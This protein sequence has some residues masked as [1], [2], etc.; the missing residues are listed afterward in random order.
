MKARIK[1]L[2]FFLLLIAVPLLFFYKIFLGYSVVAGDFSG[3]D[4][5]DLHLPLKYAAH[6]QLTKL[7]VPLWNKNLS[8][9]F[10][11]LADGHSGFFYP[12]NYLLSFFPPIDALNLDIL[13]VFIVCFIGSYL[14]FASV[15]KERHTAFFFAVTFTFSAYFIARIKHLSHTTPAS[16]FPLLLYFA[17]KYFDRKSYIYILPTSITIAFIFFAGHPQTV[18]Y[19]VFFFLIYCF[20]EI[21]RHM[22]NTRTKVILP[23][24]VTYLSLSLLLGI[25]L[26]AVQILPTVEF[27]S[28]SPRASLSKESLNAYPFNPKNLIT[29]IS[30]YFYGNPANGTYHEDIRTSGIFWENASYFGLLPFA[31]VIFSII[32][33]IR[34]KL[35][36]PYVKFYLFLAIFSALLTLGPFTPLFSYF[37]DNL[38]IFGFFRF[39]TRFN[40]YL[41]FSLSALSAFSFSYLLKRI[42]TRKTNIPAKKGSSDSFKFSWPFTRSQTAVLAIIFVLV[43]LFVFANAYIGYIP[44]NKLLVEPSYADKIKKDSRYY[45]FYSTTQYNPSPYSTLGWIGHNDAIITSRKSI[46]P[47]NS[48]LFN[49]P[50]FTD[51]SWFEGALSV[52]RRND[53]EY[54]L[55]YGNDNPVNTGRIL[56]M[57]SVKYI[58]SFSDY[59]GVEV[60]QEKK[61]D[62]G[63]PFNAPLYLY[64]NEL[65][66]PRVYFAPEAEYISDSNA[67]FEKIKDINF[68]PNKTVLLEDQPKVIP[69]EFKGA[70]DKF[71]KENTAEI[72]TDENAQVRIKAKVKQHSFLVLND[73]Y[74]PGWKAKV[75]GKPVNILRA[76]YMVR[77]LELDPGNYDIEFYYDPLSYKIGGLVSLLSLVV[78][79]FSG[80]FL[81]VKRVLSRRR[82]G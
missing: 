70:L 66:I 21:F 37:S 57:Y 15:S 80:M 41:I 44:K 36:T 51:R 2:L 73:I 27:T 76:N 75:N 14:Y 46:P 49:L 16:L 39:P 22:K 67:L 35:T 4:L 61:I 29:F 23:Q 72:V 5:L 77:A 19:N 17:K 52:R 3:S 11:I 79:I 58:L 55:L 34:K 59:L 26:A 82:R 6:Q 12:V 24:G 56:G 47:N 63:K 18:F 42:G 78:I 31:L 65:A 60:Y 1:S 74:Y 38:P 45:R 10:P 13:F 53:I 71:K 62:L 32:L 69:D 20:F 81:V 48:V 28:L 25:T 7:K 43:D 40:L 68:L 33:L 9:G 50:S 8:L 30:P 54:Y 64:R